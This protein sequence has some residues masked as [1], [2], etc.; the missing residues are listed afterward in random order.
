MKK[1][2]KAIWQMIADTFRL[3]SDGHIS[4]L[5][6]SLAYFTVFSM[7]PLLVV[8]ISLCGIFLS[9]EAIEGQVYQ[10]LVNFV[11]SDTANQLQEIIRNA[12]VQG[13]SKL[14]ALIG[15]ITLLVGATTVFAEIQD[16]INQIWGLK[17]KPSQGWLQYLKNRVLSFS[18][19]ISLGF[20]LLVSLALSAV[21]E[22]INSRLQ[23]MI[24]GATVAVFYIINLILTIGI[25]TLIFATIFRV[26][27]DARIRWRDVMAGAI[28]TAI[29]FLIGKFAISVY[30]SQAKIGST[31]GAAG[32][33]V[34][35]L[36]WV[37]YSSVILYLG[38]AF[39][40]VYAVRYGKAIEPN[41]YA[42]TIQKVEL[43]T[44]HASIQANE[45]DKQQIKG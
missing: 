16:S 41:K 32:S 12:S 21:I 28:T 17:P 22:M 18:V 2:F 5:S 14:A 7:G 34:V 43:E 33:L 42:T 15:I 31:F 10:V 37:Y 24:P 25:S 44:D 26:L 8:I 36:V 19:I 35:L 20:L 11:G 39:T 23:R 40:K 29:L 38:A 1:R 13:K 27:P 30:I 6:G 9:R 4:K 3:Y 45:R